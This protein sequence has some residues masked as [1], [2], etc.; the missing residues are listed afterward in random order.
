MGKGMGAV[1]LERGRLNGVQMFTGFRE[2]Y[3]FCVW[4]RNERPRRP[5]GTLVR[6][7]LVGLKKKKGFGL[8]TQTLKR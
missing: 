2:N 5:G 8:L 4:Q 3:G 1:G 6:V 7:S